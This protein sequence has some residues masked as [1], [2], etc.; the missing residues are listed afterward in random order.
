MNLLIVTQKVNKND[1]NLGFFHNWILEFSKHCQKLTVICLEK[2]NYNLPDNVKVLS[3]GK[4]ERASKI[5]YLWRFYKYIFKE[6]KNYDSVFVHMNVEYVILGSWF[7]K[8]WKKKI[9]LWYM[10]K[11]VTSRLKI[12]E[13]LVDIIFTGSK[14]SFRLRSKK[15]KI[16]HHGIDS[17]LFS[18]ENKDLHKPLR[19]LTVGRI[20][21]SKNIDLMIDVVYDLQRKENIDLEFTIIGETI[22]DE[23]KEYLKNIKNKIRDLNL[24]N[25]NFFGTVVNTDLPKFYQ[26]ADIFLNFSDTG[27]L[28]KSIL[29]ALSCGT[30]VISSNDSSKEFLPEGLFVERK[31]RALILNKLVNLLS[32]DKED[33]KKDLNLFV[34]NNHSLDKL[35][36][37]IIK[38]YE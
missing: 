7:W 35:V 27:S 34:R 23:D 29:E 26:E 12:A 17:Q 28:D 6:K 1:S 22:Y 9:G 4:E 31:D 10:H 36:I 5:I 24:Q 14:Y 25:I 18:F 11:S 37:K 2:G 30:Y 32:Q 8:L 20:S 38:S 3:L 21:K 16:L 15:V 13:K 33:L 19:L